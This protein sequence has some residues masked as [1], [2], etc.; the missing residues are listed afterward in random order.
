MTVDPVQDRFAVTFDLSRVIFFPSSGTSSSREEVS[1]FFSLPAWS[2]LFWSSPPRL[3]SWT[4][5]NCEL[6]LP[7][8]AAVAP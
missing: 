8:G 6:H 7:Y 4:R 5:A 1:L 3:V 2:Q